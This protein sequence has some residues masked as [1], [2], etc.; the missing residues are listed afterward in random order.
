MAIKDNY[1]PVKSTTNFNSKPTISYEAPLSIDELR[2]IGSINERIVQLYNQITKLKKEGKLEDIA[3]LNITSQESKLLSVINLQYGNR[4]KLGKEITKRV[5]EIN[6]S[7]DKQIFK[8]KYLNNNIKLSSIYETKFSNG[9]KSALDHFKLFSTIKNIPFLSFGANVVE[10]GVVGFSKGLGKSVDIFKSLKDVATN[11]VKEFNKSKNNIT[12]PRKGIIDFGDSLNKSKDNFKYLNNSANNFVKKFNKSMSNVTIPRKG[13]VEF[14]NSLGQSGKK[15]KSL[16]AGFSNFSGFLAGLKGAFKSLG[17]S[18]KV[19]ASVLGKAL[20]TTG[21]GALIVAIGSIVK[22]FDV[23]KKFNIGGIG[24]EIGKITSMVSVL[25]A[26]LDLTLAKMSQ[27]LAP[28]L[29][30]IFKGIEKIIVP[31]FNLIGSVFNSVI[32]GLVAGFGNVNDA[33]KSFKSLFSSIGEL[34]KGLTPAISFLAKVMGSLLGFAI[35]VIIKPLKWL[36]DLLSALFGQVNSATNN[37]TTANTNNINYNPTYTFNT[38][39][40]NL[41]PLYSKIKTSDMVRARTYFNG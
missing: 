22:I 34:I 14:N 30:G 33:G 3:K 11:F 18:I 9:V 35:N 26:K 6:K 5:N 17:A 8:T 40:T 32:D 27:K 2:Q 36:V 10:K 15:L 20:V 37:V 38:S 4:N 16:Q 12:I 21:I 23:M 41:E 39:N 28:I 1:K 24:T 13:I 19:V 29:K 31:I 25:V 7:L